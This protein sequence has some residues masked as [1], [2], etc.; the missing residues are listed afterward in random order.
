LTRKISI[1]G[2]KLKNGK[3]V[4]DARRLDAS[5]RIRQRASKRVRVIKGNGGKV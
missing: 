1:P 4:K 3:I 2:Y 5:A